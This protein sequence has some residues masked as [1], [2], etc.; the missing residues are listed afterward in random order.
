MSEPKSPSHPT[1]T[2]VPSTTRTSRSMK[3]AVTNEAYVRKLL[4][5]HANGM[6]ITREGVFV[7]DEM[8][9]R[10]EARVILK[11]NRIARAE[12]ART[13]KPRHAKAAVLSLTTGTVGLYAARAG[14][15]ALVAFSTPIAA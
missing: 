9:R 2:D 5:S 15:E 14:D 4:A 8:I 7:T 11:M 12:N 6:S 13:L 3:R 1:T 10:F